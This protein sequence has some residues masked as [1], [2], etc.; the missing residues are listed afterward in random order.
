VADGSLLSLMIAGYCMPFGIR[1]D[2]LKK[3]KRSGIKLYDAQK[4]LP[5]T[6]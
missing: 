6:I 1:E 3:K 2:F 5:K 4:N